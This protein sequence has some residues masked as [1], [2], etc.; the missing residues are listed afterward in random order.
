MKKLI[1]LL[2]AVSLI[3]ALVPAVASAHT[4]GDPFVTDLMAGQHIDVGD[5]LVWNDGTLLYIKY[6]ITDPEWCIT[7]THLQVAT[8]AS[9]IPQK[10]GNPIPGKFEEND[11]HDCVTEALYTYDLLEKG[12]AVD[13]GLSIAAH[14]VV[15]SFVGYENPNLD[16]FAAGLPAQ[17]TMSVQYPYSGGPSYFPVTTVTGGTSLDGTYEGWCVDTDHVIYQNT[18]YTAN[19]YSSYESLPDGLVE[20]PENLDLVNW[21]INQGYV[22]QPSACDGNYTFG[23]VQRAIWALIEDGQSTSGLYGWSQC[24]VDEILAA[25]GASGEGFTPGCDDYV[26]VILQPVDGQ[27]VISIAQV[28]FASVGV[29]CLP[30]F[31]YETA[32]GFGPGFPGKNW[33]TYI[34]YTVQGDIPVEWPEGGTLSV[35]YEDLPIGGGNDWDYNDFVVD[36]DTLATFFG[37]STDRDLIQMDFTIRPEAKMAGYTH[38]MHLDADTFQCNGTYE[39]YRDGSLV[40]SGNYNDGTGID[41]VLVPNTASYPDEV[42]LTIS[43]T[44]DCNFSF[45]TWDP[46]LYHGENLFYDPY[47]HVNNT[48]EDI[49]AGDVRM[50]TVPVDWQWPT[51]DGNAIWNVYPK[52]TAG[53]PPTF[54]PYWWTP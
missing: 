45:P 50:L 3:L 12:W 54:Q 27:Q 34:E 2:I 22:G 11:E 36:I 48:G 49:H 19:V 7:E 9:L 39:I 46:N 37:T 10:N 28:T 14:A 13:Q 23:D 52:V 33:A 25:A 24:R 21:I 6:V 43:F 38:V 31:Q 44:G 15:Q 4:E 16:N 40:G 17:V 30:L 42:L 8:N 26:A 35:A 5:V 32:W 29:P 51:P 53:S 20:Y 41:V 18:D 47:L 1:Y